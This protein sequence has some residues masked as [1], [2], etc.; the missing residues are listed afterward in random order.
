MDVRKED[1]KAVWNKVRRI[2]LWSVPWICGVMLKGN[3][4]EECL[5]N[6]EVKE[7]EGIL[8]VP[9]RMAQKLEYNKDIL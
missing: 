1:I 2:V 4:K 7:F 5:V 3:M 6:D 9:K 8:F